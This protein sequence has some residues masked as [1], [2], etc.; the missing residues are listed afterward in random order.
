MRLSLTSV[1]F[2]AMFAS[3]APA[4][5][6]SAPP[7]FNP[8]AGY[9]AF[10]TRAG[11]SWT[12]KDSRGN[13]HD[14][15]TPVYNATTGV[16]I[17]HN[18]SGRNEY[19]EAKRTTDVYGQP[20][21]NVREQTPGTRMSLWGKLFASRYSWMWT[22]HDD[23]C[24][25]GVRR[26]SIYARATEPAGV[27]LRPLVYD[28]GASAGT[29]D[30]GITQ[31]VLEPGVGML[32]QTFNTFAGPNAWELVSAKTTVGQ[33][34][35]VLHG[36]ETTL[37]LTPSSFT[38][39]GIL[40]PGTG[41]Y[42]P[43]KISAKLEARIKPGSTRTHRLQFNDT[44]RLE[45]ELYDEQNDMVYRWS[46]GRGFG[47]MMGWVDLTPSRPF[48][49]TITDIAMPGPIMDPLGRYRVRVFITDA[50]ARRTGLPRF[51]AQELMAVRAGV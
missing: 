18:L 36:V 9:T 1:V 12:F 17:F 50:E 21:V 37:T 28:I 19:S 44:Q 51:S 16:A 47:Q 4:L 41:G 11:N 13:L 43:P 48:S 30:C 40:P 31:I 38:Y 23:P 7:V 39:P 35:A 14:I 3:T 46:D 34:P 27:F 15:R 26:S 2:A 45:V 25:S 10:P 20:I 29:A 49:H 22:G 42:R 5:A 6:Q 32:E 24:M 33:I 8:P